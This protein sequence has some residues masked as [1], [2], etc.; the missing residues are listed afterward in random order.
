MT[1]E[2]KKV[3]NKMKY[4]NAETVLDAFLNYYGTRILSKDFIEFLYREFYA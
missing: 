4:R 1:E 3:Y 2:Q